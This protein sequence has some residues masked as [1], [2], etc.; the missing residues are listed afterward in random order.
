MILSF[1][2]QI[3]DESETDQIL[4][5]KYFVW[6]NYT[7][8][9]WGLR[10]AFNQNSIMQLFNGDRHIVHW[11]TFLSSTLSWFGWYS[12]KITL[13]VATIA[14]FDDGGDRSRVCGGKDDSWGLWLSRK[15]V[16]H[17]L[18]PM[19]ILFSGHIDDDDDK[20]PL[21]EKAWS[22]GGFEESICL[23]LRM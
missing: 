8:G 12:E 4:N 7:L 20:K 6:K 1:R 14:P 2:P 19:M 21:V 17:C 9:K 23:H 10:E 15:T 16:S 22:L 13:L 18:A 11:D 3:Y 5:A